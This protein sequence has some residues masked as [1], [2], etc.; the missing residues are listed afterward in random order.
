MKNFLKISLTAVAATLLMTSCNCFKSMVKEAESVK[1]TCTPSVLELKGS[2]VTADIQ[3]TFPA[4]YFN[5][6]AIVKA[7][8][9]L[10]F[11]GGEI[12]GV[13]KYFQGEKIKDNYTVVD[14]KNGG[15]YKQTVTF[16]YDA[17]AKVCTLEVR[18]EA[19]CKNDGQYYTEV[20]AIPVA[21]GISTL[22]N[23]M[24]YF[25]G[26]GAIMPDN[27][28]RITTISEKADIMYEINRSNVRKNQLTTE[29]IKLFEEFVKENSDKDRVTLGNIYAKGYASPDGPE[30]FN[31]QLSKKRSE[32]GKKAIEEQLKGVGASYDAAAYG[33]DWEGFK[34]LV[35]ASNIEDKALI[36][37]VLQMYSSPAQRDKEIQNMSAVFNVLKT[38]ILPKLRRTQ[39]VA[40]A[41]V[42]GL[43]D[44]E[45]KAAVDKNINSLNLEEMLY[46]A[47]LFNDNATKI[48]I[49]KAAAKK[50]NDVRA[51]NNLGVVL[52]QE[53]DI[54]EA[55]AAL[56][57]AAKLDPSASQI[58]NN[59][60]MAAL[61]QGNVAE[62]KKYL[63]AIS[64]PEAAK[65]KA[66]VAVAEGD[67][68]N[69]S[70]VLNGYNAALVE[71]LNGNLSKAKGLL[72]SE[73]SADAEYLRAVIASKEGNASA[74]M[75]Y[76]K[77]ACSKDKS[78]VKKAKKDVNFA[79]LF[80]TTEFLA[81]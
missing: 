75:N 78:L 60:A 20:V 57:K 24:D 80:G 47:T 4:G 37:Q 48:D 58:S 64:G 52:G 56:K 28:K 17:R 10:V 34:E 39:L 40:E 65:A 12:V 46:A 77:S 66:M 32:T 15:S 2:T 62:A 6:K 49:Y 71:V 33:E 22:Q 38:D 74:A 54:E 59:L 27:F 23:D 50:Y 7:T 68:T 35:E 9:V 13:T 36:L 1:Y 70:N 45:I 25:G 69:A 81:L 21:Q 5:K 8:P 67:Y 43:S 19:T 18:L 31:D 30:K 61:A 63:G 26:N 73:T 55:T 11:E 41:D 72:S 76:L 44:A 53:G 79:S 3:V 42:E 14:Y 16:P 29:Q 51:Y